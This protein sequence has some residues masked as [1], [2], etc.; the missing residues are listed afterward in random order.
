MNEER[1]KKLD[2]IIERAGYIQLEMEEIL[3]ELRGQKGKPHQ[4]EQP[5]AREASDDQVPGV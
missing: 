1:A 2:K 3:K 4:A 5:E